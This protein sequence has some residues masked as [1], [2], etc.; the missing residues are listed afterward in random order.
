MD[1]E[2]YINHIVLDGHLNSPIYKPI[3]KNT[4]QE[5]FQNLSKLVNKYYS[6]LTKKEKYAE[7]VRILLHN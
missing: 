2:Y 7:N 1:K 6:N 5:L 4:D 3:T